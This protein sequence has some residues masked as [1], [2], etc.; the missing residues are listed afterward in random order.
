MLLDD[1]VD[2]GEHRKF[3]YKDLHDAETSLGATWH[4]VERAPEGPLKRWIPIGRSRQYR[5]GRAK[6]MLP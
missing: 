1:L 6:E 3:C 5:A 2:V 4:T